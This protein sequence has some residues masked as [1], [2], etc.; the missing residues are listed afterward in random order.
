MWSYCDESTRVH[1]IRKN[2]LAG[3][4]PR[5]PD[6]Q[7]VLSTRARQCFVA[8][9]YMR[10]NR[11]TIN[12]LEAR[13]QLSSY[14]AGGNTSGFEHTCIFGASRQHVRGP[15][16][17][18][19]PIWLLKQWLCTSSA[20]ARVP[21]GSTTVVLA[22][23]DGK[24]PALASEVPY[25]PGVR[26]SHAEYPS[27]TAPLDCGLLCVCVCVCVCVCACVRV[28]GHECES[29]IVVCA[30]IR[31]ERSRHICAN[32]RAERDLCNIRVQK[33]LHSHSR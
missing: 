3:K 32:T 17:M 10:I 1:R 31:S 15:R 21:L 12:G 19:S 27:S 4:K 28:C 16:G 14:S 23:N 8:R 5:A 13:T 29:L 33:P 7:S 30:A 9:F 22:K 20:L 18:W 26:P 11:L 24:G 25:L 6:N 2:H